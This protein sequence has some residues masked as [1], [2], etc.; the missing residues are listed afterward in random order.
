MGKAAV[1]P[2]GLMT[3]LPLWVCCSVNAVGWWAG[4]DSLFFFTELL[5]DGM[6][7]HLWAS[8]RIAWMFFAE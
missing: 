1:L 7:R 4:V 8:Q 5:Q 6:S 2:R 3:V